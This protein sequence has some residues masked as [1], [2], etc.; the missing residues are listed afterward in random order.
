[1]VFLQ[2]SRPLELASTEAVVVDAEVLRH[3]VQLQRSL[4][5]RHLAA[6]DAAPTDSALV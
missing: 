3:Y 4:Q 1:M 2:Q 6:E 5:G